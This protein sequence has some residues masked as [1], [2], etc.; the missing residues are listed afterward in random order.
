LIFSFA[1]SA[2]I[3]VLMEML[4]G[5]IRSRRDVEALLPVAPLA[6]LPWIETNA[7]RTA[8]ARVR[9]FSFAGAVTS[10]VLAAVLVHFLYRPLDVLWQVAL[11]RLTG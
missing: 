3:A 1:S 10:V 6:V 8:R 2:G 7:E 9:K 4:D 11:R 5:S